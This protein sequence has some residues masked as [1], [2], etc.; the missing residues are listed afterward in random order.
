VGAARVTRLA[1]HLLVFRRAE[2]FTIVVIRRSRGRPNKALPSVARAQDRKPIAA[3]CLRESRATRS[4]HFCLTRRG[5]NCNISFLGVEK[6]AVR[7]TASPRKLRKSPDHREITARLLHLTARR[8]RASRCQNPC[9][10][11]C[12][13]LVSVSTCASVRTDRARHCKQDKSSRYWSHGYGG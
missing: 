3:L 13:C 12:A 10:F 9:T 6:I 7:S 1:A 5:S 2:G 11:W 4:F 8:R